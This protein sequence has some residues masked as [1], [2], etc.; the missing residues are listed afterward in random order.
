MKYAKFLLRILAPAAAVAVSML[1]AASSL[2]SA[3]LIKLNRTGMHLAL[4]EATT[5]AEL[6]KCKLLSRAK[7]SKLSFDRSAVILSDT[8]YVA[9]SDLLACGERPIVL[10]E[11]PQDVG[12]LVDVNISNALYLTLDVI[13][14]SPLA[15]LATVSRFGS[16][17]NLTAL[18]G[19]YVQG[20]SLSELQEQGFS[21]D[22]NAAPRI[23]PSGLYVSPGGEPDCSAN[24]YPGVWDL[25]KGAR[26]IFSGEGRA[27]Q[28]RCNKLFRP[29]AQ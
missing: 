6:K 29:V 28:E 18:P 22:P 19:A 3:V 5:G 8:S 15:F 4:T 26:V 2:G 12:T 21:Y 11:I 24:A 14:T 13:S 17:R 9:M 10:T 25:A 23:S 16:S 20:R 1:A 7:F 27:I